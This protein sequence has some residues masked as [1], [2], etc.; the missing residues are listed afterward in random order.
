MNPDKI[1]L[2]A[3]L[4]LISIGAIVDGFDIGE[5]SVCTNGSYAGTTNNT[6]QCSNITTFN[7]TLY[8]NWTNGTNIINRMDSIQASIPTAATNGT[9]TLAGGKARIYSTA[10]HHDSKVFYNYQNSSGLNL[11]ILYEANR[12]ES[13]S[14]DIIDITTILDTNKIAWQIVN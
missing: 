12:N 11:G 10:I 9:A 1:A 3:L 7:P 4:T 13:T 14:F 5:K 6:W 8:V 2:L